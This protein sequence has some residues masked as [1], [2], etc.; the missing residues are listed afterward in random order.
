MD[1]RL[2][3]ARIRAPRA[4]D[5]EAIA[6]HLD[7]RALWRN[8]RDRVPHPYGIDDARAF[9]ANFLPRDP[10]E[11]FAIEV[12]GECAGMIGLHPLGDVHRRSAEL[13]FWLGRAHHGLGIVSEAAP[14]IVA[15]GFA[16]DPELVRIEARV[17]DWNAPSARVLEKTGFVLEGRLRLAVWKDGELC[18]LLVFGMLRAE[19]ARHGTTFR[20]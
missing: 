13:G 20:C 17:H 9:L 18:D 3:R 14:R 19:A 6:R 7:D 10:P 16:R 8:L 4:D 2:T 15:H 5:A 1:I 11:A 12:D